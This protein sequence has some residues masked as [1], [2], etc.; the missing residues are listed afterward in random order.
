MLFV[1]CWFPYFELKFELH[2]N[3]GRPRLAGLASEL[4]IGRYQLPSPKNP[5][6]PVA[7]HE[8]ALLTEAKHHLN[9]FGG[10][11]RSEDFNRNILPLSLPLIQAIGHRMALEAAK[12]ANIDSK[13]L[14]L[15][16][17]GVALEDS[18]WYTEQGGMSRR[19]QR[20][21]EAQ[22]ADALLPDLEKL[23]YET[24]AAPYSNAPMASERLWNTFVS[25]LEVFSGE[26]SFD[27]GM[28]SEP[29]AKL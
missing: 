3:R 29:L 2:A 23:V 4:L 20:E 9:Q 17:S 28:S 21:M 13:L 11:H 22:A 5:N 6:S 18:A 12:E 15:Y 1:R 27:I 8:A 10:M 7:R 26:A 25:E 16:E 24:G 14:A 19:A